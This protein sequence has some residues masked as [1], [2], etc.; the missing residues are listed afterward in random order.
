LV[1]VV[2]HQVD[3]VT[4]ATQQGRSVRLLTRRSNA[5]GTSS[6]SSPC[7][8]VAA[9]V[10]AT[11]PVLPPALL[12]ASPSPIDDEDTDFVTIVTG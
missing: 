4:Q 10:V 7:P 11:A 5:A 2:A 12:Q 1:S 8:A 6:S 9:T 3:R